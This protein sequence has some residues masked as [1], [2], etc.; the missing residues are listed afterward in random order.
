MGLV[1]AEPFIAAPDEEG[2]GAFSLE[3]EPPSLEEHGGLGR[4]EE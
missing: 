1:F 4:A 2:G 3:C